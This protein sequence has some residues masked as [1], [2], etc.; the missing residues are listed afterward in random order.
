MFPIISIEIPASVTT[1]EDYAFWISQLTNFTCQE[2]SKLASI[3]TQA[4]AYTSLTSITIPDSVGTISSSAFASCH[5]QTIKINCQTLNH[6]NIVT[7]LN[8]IGNRTAQIHTLQIALSSSLLDSFADDEALKDYVAEIL[9]IPTDNAL[10]AAILEKHGLF[11]L[12]LSNTDFTQEDIAGLPKT[13]P[14]T[15]IAGGERKTHPVQ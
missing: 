13:L 4:F 6:N 11:E 9:A 7:V 12:D 5:L 8:N 2:N 10:I 1:I 14:W 15:V 3:G